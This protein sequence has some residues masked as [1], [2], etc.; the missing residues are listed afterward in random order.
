MKY[1]RQ[2]KRN[3][4]I[5]GGLGLLL[6]LSPAARAQV[7]DSGSILNQVESVTGEAERVTQDLESN[8]ADAVR[9][10]QEA[11]NTGELTDAVNAGELI[12]TVNVD[13]LTDALDVDELTDAVNAGELINAVESTLDPLTGLPER[14]PI[15]NAGGATVFVDVEV[16]N[17]WRAVE[18]Q[19]LV[20]LE[21]GELAVLRQLDI[22]ILEQTDFGGLGLSLLRFR[23]PKEIDSRDALRRLLPAALVD[24]FDRNHIYNPQ[25]YNPQKADGKTVS[26]EASEGASSSICG[27]SLN[28]GMVDTAIQLD[29]PAFGHSRIREKSFLEQ[30]IDQPDAHGT[31]VAGLF[32][33][34]IEQMPPRLPGATLYN[35][36]VFYSR[37]QYAQGATMMHLVEALNWLMSKDV[38][39]IN[40]SLSG[41]D[42]RILAAAVDQVIGRGKA[43]VAAAGNAGPAAP[44]LYPAAYPGVISATAV[45]SEQRIYRWANR[46]EHV[47]F[48]AF[49][50][51]VVTA[52]SG[53]EFGRESGTSMAAPVVSA[54]VACELA[55]NPGGADEVI[56]RLANRALDLGEPGRDPVFGYGLLQ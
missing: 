37:N 6:C 31:A 30:D 33:G 42:N 16:E 9:E 50:V 43:I 27:Q 4:L 39:V 35:A 32:V 7:L 54:F 56:D 14:L 5:V 8:A 24:R 11:V 51:S 25:I 47:D 13:E 18:R 44:P 3:P 23:V 21:P 53:S 22:E 46:G 41:P 45:D 55:D 38:E 52:R 12:D 17:G 28:I 19:W 2:K 29:H 10:T 34:A 40:M 48:A 36:S 15:V 1:H 49:G 26:Q 20:M